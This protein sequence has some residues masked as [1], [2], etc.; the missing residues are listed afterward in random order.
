[1]VRNL[2]SQLWCF[3]LFFGFP[4]L[5]F[6]IKNTPNI[7]LISIDD[8]NN[9]VGCLG[10]HPQAHTPN[11]D[12]LA[13]RGTLFTNA[14]CQ[15][16]VCNPSRASMMTGKY[17]HSS[18]LYFLSPGIRSVPTFKNGRTLP[19][20]FSD[21]GYKTL[22]AGKIF[23]GGDKRFFQ[24]YF[25]TSKPGAVGGVFG[26]MPKKKV[27]QC[28]GDRLWDWGAFPN[29]DELMPDRRAAQWAVTQLNKNHEK[30]FFMGVGFARP[31]VPMCVPQ[32]WFDLYPR[33]K[34]IL[35]LTKNNDLDDLSSYAIDLTSLHHVAPKHQWMV[36]SGQ[37]K[38][39]VQAYLASITF[40]DHCLG[41]VLDALEASRY[42]DN[43][44]IV[45]FSD[46]GFHL[47]EKQ[48]WAKRSL[49]EDST[50]VP[51]IISTPHYRKKQRS[52]K[53]VELIDLFPTLL[54][55]ANLPN[56]PNQEGQS[57]VPL[58]KDPEAKWTYP[59]I[60]SF[61]LGNYS[62]RS[63]R[64]RYIQ[65]LDG[66]KELYDLYQD[67]HEWENLINDP[68]KQRIINKHAVFIPQEAHPIL[69]GKSTGHKAYQAAY[70]ENIRN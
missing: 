55:L 44:I 51:L 17:P 6:G 65:Y 13:N 3:F 15:S 39:A 11:I 52:R 49:W 46:H 36:E 47:G 40:V 31:H 24:E 69:P 37:W 19:E 50:N 30:P 14:H 21:N 34:I 29:S 2:N 8:L 57:L 54:D 58:I 48:R 53:P 41:M 70:Q 62:V 60:T 10:G 1:M 12:R 7:L 4:Y 20:V 42:A 63:T 5:T 59:A 66:S 61:G 38:H 45:L 35:P 22:A 56:D 33:E 9:W 32:K 18:G 16:P 67:P 68:K 26:P 28:P 27:S 23:H 43:T 64:Y 25:R